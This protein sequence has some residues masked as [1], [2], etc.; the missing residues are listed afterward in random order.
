MIPYLNPNIPPLFTQTKMKRTLSGLYR[1]VARVWDCNFVPNYFSLQ[2]D[3]IKG[4]T[5]NIKSGDERGR[6]SEG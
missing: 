1:T 6:H 4:G 3:K 5:K 2:R